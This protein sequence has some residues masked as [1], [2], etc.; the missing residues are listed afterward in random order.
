MKILFSNLGYAKGISGSLLH[1]ITLAGRHIY[2]RPEAQRRVLAQFRAIMDDEKPDLCCLV[3][4]DRGSFHS[5]YFNQLLA[6]MCDNYCFHDIA[7]KYG[8]QSRL[9]RMP[10]HVGKSNAFIARS[11]Y[12]FERTYFTHGTKR[13]I[14]K[15]LLS[16]ECTLFFAHFSLQKD[17]RAR[18]F[19][20][21]E[22]LVRACGMESLILADFNILTGVGELQPLL[23]S[24]GLRL[25]NRTDEHTF[26]FHRKRLMLDLCLC[27]PHLVERVTLRVIP[28]PFSDHAA[29]VVEIA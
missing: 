3:E 22:Q 2:S 15:I 19:T 5:G 26:T 4:I 21:L 28:Q 25:L 6:L 13:L 16:P 10:L 23:E 20:E 12:P 17:V 18:Q 11:E 27:S 8:E 1:H 14:Y 24:S 9:G 7:D 29:L